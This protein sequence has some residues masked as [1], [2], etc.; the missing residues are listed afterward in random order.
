MGL[1]AKPKLPARSIGE[2]V[3]ASHIATTLTK[4][5]WEASTVWPI[6]GIGIASTFYLTKAWRAY[7]RCRSRRSLPMRLAR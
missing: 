4:T 3:L 6:P 1:E 5:L 2:A 7:L